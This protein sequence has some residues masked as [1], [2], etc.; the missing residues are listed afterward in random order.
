MTLQEILVKRKFLQSGDTAMR[1]FILNTTTQLVK[2][3]LEKLTPKIISEVNDIVSNEI[4][5]LRHNVKKGDQGD[6]PVAGIDYQIPKD[7]KDYI[8]TEADKKQIVAKIK[9]PI[10]EKV[11]EKTEIIKEQP[12]ITNE[13]KE[14]AK[15]ES[16]EQIA[17]KLNTLKEKVEISVIKGLNKYLDNLRKSIRE[18]TK[19]SGGGGGMGNWVTE[20][21]SGTINGINTTFT[22]PSNVASN[23]KAIILLYNGQVQE[24][25]NH[26]TVS[27]KTITM[28]FAPET[29]STLFVMFIRA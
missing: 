11:I 3:A 23:G 29:G 24:Y 5:D 15:Y 9:V 13:I 26:F 4:E 22:I 2:D 14:V 8:L 12:I 7:G 1:S 21:P 10:V 17:D 6:K 18:K 19:F 20:S 16:P 27:G 25:T 28:T